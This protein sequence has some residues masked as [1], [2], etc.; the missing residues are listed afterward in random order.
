MHET[1]LNRRLRGSHRHLDFDLIFHAI[2]LLGIN[3]VAISLDVANV[4]LI[5]ARVATHT[6]GGVGDTLLAV[7]GPDLA[8]G[9]LLASKASR[10]EDEQR[11]GCEQRLFHLLNIKIVTI[12]SKET[13]PSVRAIGRCTTRHFFVPLT[14]IASKYKRFSTSSIAIPDESNS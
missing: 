6:I 14:K 4:V 7:F 9:V 1:I 3:S 10:R 12:C 11:D 13:I 8:F 5:G 2:G